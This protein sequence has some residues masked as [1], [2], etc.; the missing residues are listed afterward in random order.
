MA[1]ELVYVSKVGNRSYWTKAHHFSKKDDDHYRWDS[2]AALVS[3]FDQLRQDYPTIF[4]QKKVDRFYIG[5]PGTTELEQLTTVTDSTANRTPVP[6]EVDVSPSWVSAKMAK[7]V[8]KDK[9]YYVVATRHEDSYHFLD[10][11]LYE[12]GGFVYPFNA[13]VR[14]WK[15]EEKAVATAKTLTTNQRLWAKYPTFER[16]YLTVLDVRD[17]QVI[18]STDEQQLDSIA[19]QVS[20]LSERLERL[21]QRLVSHFNDGERGTLTVTNQTADQPAFDLDTYN[22]VE[23]FRCLKYV[24]QCLVHR[25]QL[26]Q[27]LGWY[28]GKIIQDQLHMV[29]LTDLAA[30]DADKFVQYLQETRRIR[31]EAKDLAV[32]V[33]TVADN[34]DVKNILNKLTGNMSLANHYQFRDHHAAEVLQN[35]ILAVPRK[36]TATTIN[37]QTTRKV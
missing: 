24:L 33:N 3:A 15:E 31:R 28:D 30:I 16:Q 8:K 21:N 12:N 20:Q 32:L 18:W 13:N 17:G 23:F 26:N 6:A 27:F 19:V 5:Q 25:D 10:T 2:R 36:E 1:F 9:K 35:L 22:A 37:A 29:E 7:K 14:R 4:G 11:T 34:M